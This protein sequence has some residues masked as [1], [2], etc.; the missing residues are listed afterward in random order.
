MNSSPSKTLAVVI[1]K[2]PNCSL[3]NAGALVDWCAQLADAGLPVSHSIS[4]CTGN[5]S[6]APVVQWN[7]RYLTECSPEKLTE[8]WITDDF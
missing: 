7:G 8:Q 3:N 6:E 5:C 1:C 2:G 4:G